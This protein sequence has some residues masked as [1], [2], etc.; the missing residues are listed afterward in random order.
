M[1]FNL[2]YQ[3][4]VYQYQAFLHIETR[5]HLYRKPLCPVFLRSKQ[6]TVFYDLVMVSVSWV[7]YSCPIPQAQEIP[8]IP[9]HP[10]TRNFWHDVNVRGPH[11]C[12]MHTHTSML[13]HFLWFM[14][15][16]WA[17]ACPSQLLRSHYE[18]ESVHNCSLIKWGRCSEWVLLLASFSL[19]PS[20]DCTTHPICPCP[21]SCCILHLL[22][23]FFKNKNCTYP[24]PS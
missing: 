9:T 21:G 20:A 3:N 18:I 4:K 23:S 10:S 19:P 14:T 15:A 11:S 16:G 7:H 1:E 2:N 12:G 5:Q 13:V 8:A 24:A 6:D 22:F 17:P